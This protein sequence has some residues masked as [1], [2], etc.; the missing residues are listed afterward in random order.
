MKYSDLCG[1]GRLISVKYLLL[2]SGLEDSTF[3]KGPGFHSVDMGVEL[4][5]ESRL[6]GFTWA[7]AR[8]EYG[9]E[10]VSRPLEGFRTEGAVAHDVSLEEPWSALI[11]RCLLR[12]EHYPDDGGN[13]PETVE[14]VFESEVRIF[15]AAAQYDLGRNRFLPRMDELAVFFEE[16]A[17]RRAKVL[18][19][20]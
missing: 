19:F 5:F 8:D 11:G 16:G 12:E 20:A 4:L 3:V 13:Y 17:I 7:Q 18:P 6:F 2:P 1:A 10:C 14:L 9:V 15:I